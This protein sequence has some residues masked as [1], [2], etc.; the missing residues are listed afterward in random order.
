MFFT[1]T[2]E[3]W[4][5]IVASLRPLIPAGTS[6]P[7]FHHVHLAVPDHGRHATFTAGAFDFFL[8]RDAATLTPGRA[9]TIC[10]AHASLAKIR[11]DKDSTV[12]LDLY[13]GGRKVEIQYVDSGRP[14]TARL[15]TLP[16]A[17]FPLP[18]ARPVDATTTTTILP[19]A[20][21]AALATTLHAHSKDETRYV[22]NGAFLDPRDGG[23][24]VAT[25]GRRLAI[26]HAPVLPISCIVPTAAVRVLLKLPARAVRATLFR[27]D[28]TSFDM[29][30]LQPGPA[31]RLWTKLVDGSFPNY[32][33]IIPAAETPHRITF[34]DPAGVAAWLRK[35][36]K[37]RGG[38]SV[39]L[40]CHPP[41]TVELHSS[42]PDVGESAARFTAYLQGEPERIA[43]NPGFLAD[44]LENMPGT[45]HVFDGMSPATV[46][47]PDS[48]AVLMPMRVMDASPAEAKATYS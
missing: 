44:T 32:L 10:L 17:E 47:R 39:R 12:R 28:K 35:L 11:G 46:R 29:L 27:G 36:P 9:G 14:A 19:A 25:D 20:T 30:L 13:D 48:L 21:L 24:I 45:L 4:R 33:Q 5:E 1:I 22:L 23:Q 6:I 34:A 7:V 8:V 18:G 43:F 3:S 41:A 42:V 38:E 31:I 16:G 37:G 15:V 26:A 2:A 40:T